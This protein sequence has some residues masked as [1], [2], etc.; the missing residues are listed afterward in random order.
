MKSWEKYSQTVVRAS[1]HSISS[2]VAMM[3][4]FLASESL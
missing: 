1:A 4:D 2:M 3:R